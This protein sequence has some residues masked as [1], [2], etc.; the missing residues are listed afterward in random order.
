MEYEKLKD[1]YEFTTN[2][3]RTAEYFLTT[4][5]DHQ[6]EIA[7]ANEKTGLNGFIAGGAVRDA[8]LGYS[9]KDVDVFIPGCADP[10]EIV[11]YSEVLRESNPSR[12]PSAFAISGITTQHGN[13]Y[14]GRNG[15]GASK[16][17]V[18]TYANFPAGRI[19]D[20]LPRRTNIQIIGRAETTRKEIV[21]NFDYSLV[22]AFL[23]ND[24][25][26]IHPTFRTSWEKRRLEPA[27]SRSTYH[28]MRNWRDRTGVRIT[29]PRFTLK[30][31]T[32]LETFAFNE[33]INEAPAMPGPDVRVV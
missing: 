29:I 18:V 22:K 1:P 32:P 2:Q 5:R 12:Y 25:L 17:C 6:R 23:L 26:Y 20:L 27:R 24:E 19:G 10:D 21:D 14:S 9:W 15:Q 16:F 3:K 11:Y 30:D 7:Y 33:F 31:T 8:L 28:R 4:F 13:E